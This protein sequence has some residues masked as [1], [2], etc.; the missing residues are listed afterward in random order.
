MYIKILLFETYLT[1]SVRLVVGEL[2]LLKGHDLFP[3]LFA[4]ERRVGM[5]V[6][7]VGRRGI[8]FA[9]DQPRRAVVSVAVAFV[10]ARHDVQED[11]VLLVGVQVV[12]AAPD[13]RKHTPAWKKRKI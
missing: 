9:G 8:G 13:C 4:G 3:Q 2:D 6:E 11:P 1:R 7:A 10:V 12:K 5:G